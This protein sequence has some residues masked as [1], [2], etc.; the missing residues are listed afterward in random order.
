[1]V[2]AGLGAVALVAFCLSLILFS[3]NWKRNRYGGINTKAMKRAPVICLGIALPC[4]FLMPIIYMGLK[5]Q[6]FSSWNEHVGE[7]MSSYNAMLEYQNEEYI[8]LDMLIDMNQL[9]KS[10]CK[11]YLRYMG[12]K[13][14]ATGKKGRWTNDAVYEI[15][16]ETGF[17]LIYV[18]RF[19]RVDETE[20]E[21][22]CDD[23]Y[24][25]RQDQSAFLAACFEGEDTIYYM[26]EE[27]KKG[28]LED[29]GVCFP[30][31]EM[32]ITT[33]L[34]GSLYFL[35][36]TEPEYIQSFGKKPDYFMDALFMGGLFYRRFHL[37]YDRD[38]EK[39]Y[40][41]MDDEQGHPK[42]QIFK[43]PKK[44]QKYMNTLSKK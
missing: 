35:E 15:E 7:H 31:K 5:P 12:T 29:Q 11:G 14:T 4:F 43:L 38:V 20:G 13:K 36:E 23:L 44:G 19:E 24:C 1:M 26:Y 6:T 41:F 32:G 40:C 30:Q 22:Y 42:E 33:D 16:N 25:R 34:W 17:S 37:C 18:K 21:I 8:R 3:A 10:E 28:D 9:K 27:T 39:W 2:E